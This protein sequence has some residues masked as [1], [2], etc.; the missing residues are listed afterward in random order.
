MS[1]DC[2][3]GAARLN[4]CGCCEGLTRATPAV[5]HNRHG[6][7]AIDYRVGTHRSFRGAMVAN[8]SNQRALDD[9]TTR[10]DDDYTI[11][12]L[13]AWAQV[14][15]VVTF[16][17]ERIA[18]EGFLATATERRSLVWLASALGYVP[19]PGVAAAGLASFEMETAPGAP[20]ATTVPEGV[21]VQSLPGPGEEPQTYETTAEIEARPAWNAIA[22]RTNGPAVVAPGQTRLGLVGAGLR[23]SVGDGLLLVARARELSP[24]SD[25]W[26]LRRVVRVEADQSGRITVL[27]L[28]QPLGAVFGPDPA[29]R[30]PLSEPWLTV[31]VMRNRCSVFGHNAVDWDL[32]P[33]ETKDNFVSGSGSGV[34]DVRP[35]KGQQDGFE[36]LMRIAEGGGDVDPG[37]WP[38]FGSV[39]DDTVVQLDGDQPDIV[40]GQWLVVTTPSVSG[41]FTVDGAV[42]SAATD[43]GLTGPVTEVDL[44]GPAIHQS[45]DGKRR[46]IAVHG[47]PE[48]VTL[49]PVE[50]VDPVYGADLSPADPVELPLGRQLLVAGPRAVLRLADDLALEPDDGGPTVTVTVESTVTVTA[51]PID[52]GGG[53]IRWPVETDEGRTGTIVG[54]RAAIEVATPPEDAPIVVEPATLAGGASGRDNAGDGLLRLTAPLNTVFDRAAVRVHANVAPVTHGAST[55]EVLG[56]GRASARW[57]RFILR[58]KPVTHVPTS[59]GGGGIGGGGGATSTLVVRVNQVRWA[60]VRSLALAGPTDRVY[61]VDTDDDGSVTVLFGDGETGARLPT[62]TDNVTAEYRVGSGRAGT[63]AAG[64]LSLLVDRPLGVKAVTNPLAPDGAADPEAPESLRA[65]LPGTVKSFDRLVSLL[66]HQDYALSFPGVAKAVA[67]WLWNGSTRLIHVTVAGDDGDRLLDDG[68][69]LT[70]LRTNMAAAAGHVN[71]IRLAG[72]EPL[73][74]TVAAGLF[75]D[76]AYDPDVVV[77]EARASLLAAFAFDERRFGQPVAVSD[78]SRSLHVPGVLGVDVDRVAVV[79]ESGPEGSTL[80]PQPT[81]LVGAEVLPAQLLVIDEPSTVVEAIS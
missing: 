54:D 7:S 61:R 74:F 53:Q 17:Q 35:P 46:A 3:C 62:G 36:L 57:Q 43:F 38:G 47:A 40:A 23:I 2:G 10:A 31:H 21:A 45:F 30:K 79:G 78:L 58:Q 70:N 60:E 76:P 25:A 64:Q 34:D 18:N 29:L 66:D 80:V 75:I 33:Q 51:P 81:R 56:G 39:F 42:A 73:G 19:S 52:L 59:I 67:T 12:L 15:D 71:P 50:L 24:D 22:V 14:A 11:A 49:A 44:A 16:Y 1:G 27:D 55:T 9:L 65:A 69:V 8:L 72:H 5:V 68:T 77:A 63:V 28:D 32:L 48:R 41:L 37:Q 4:G 26:E 6:K 13:D 20:E